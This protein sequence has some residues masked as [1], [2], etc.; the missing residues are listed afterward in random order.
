MEESK[1]FPLNGLRL[2]I[3]AMADGEIEGTFL[4]PMDGRRVA[5]AGYQDFLVKADKLF[6]RYGYPQSFQ[7]KRSFVK[8]KDQETAPYTG[9][10]PAVIKA[11]DILLLRGRF[12]TYNVIVVA[13]RNASWQGV[14]LGED[15]AKIGVYD[16][17]IQLIRLLKASLPG[18]KEEI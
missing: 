17:E 8:K 18:E 3:D 11:E 9:F 7:E 14:L 6:D 1:Y 4:S 13:R 2:C 10:P 16:G 5:F 12:S 15:G